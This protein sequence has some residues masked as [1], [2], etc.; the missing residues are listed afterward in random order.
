MVNAI[1][2]N[3]A[4]QGCLKYNGSGPN[5]PNTGNSLYLSHNNSL[6]ISGGSL[7]VVRYQ[8]IVFH[9]SYASADKGGSVKI[10]SNLEISQEGVLTVNIGTMDS[11][12]PVS[13]QTVKQ[14][15]GSLGHVTTSELEAKNYVTRPQHDADLASRVE[16]AGGIKKLAY[17]S[18]D[19]Y[20]K[21][22]VKDASTLY[23]LY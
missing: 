21:L 7:G 2:I 16:C 23:L 11:E 1:C 5:G 20:G 19:E 4:Q 6:T 17:M 13:G 10:G 15:I 22:A 8:D 18:E 9:D 3:L 14:H 12:L